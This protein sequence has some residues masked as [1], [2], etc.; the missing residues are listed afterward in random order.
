[1]R[2]PTFRTR[3]TRGPLSAVV[4]LALLFAGCGDEGEGGDT[5]AIKSTL[6]GYI[7]AVLDDDGVTACSYFTPA[8]KARTLKSS[9]AFAPDVTTCDEALTKAFRGMSAGQ[10]TNALEFGAFTTKVS[11]NNAA[12]RI[13]K[14]GQVTNLVKSGGRW[15]ISS[16]PAG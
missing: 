7:S 1:M 9:Q 2:R 12:V 4:A 11:G 14:T 5:G 3:R 6:R 8:M 10:K 13:T 16:A 15:L